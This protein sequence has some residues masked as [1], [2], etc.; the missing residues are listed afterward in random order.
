MNSV[1][2]VNG[3]AVY[4]DILQDPILKNILHTFI[5]EFIP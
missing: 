1:V 3:K 4:M 5:K 2:Y